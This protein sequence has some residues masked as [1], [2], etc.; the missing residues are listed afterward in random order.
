MKTAV[1]KSY[2]SR[3]TPFSFANGTLIVLLCLI[4]LYPLWYCL[5]SSFSDGALIMQGKITIWP[6][7]FNMENYRVLLSYSMIGRAYI[8]TLFYVIAGTTLS[9]ALTL[10]AAYPL[11]RPEFKA[12]RAMSFFIAFTMLFNGGMVP[13]FIVVQGLGLMDTVLAFILPIA[14]SAYNVIVLRTFMQ[15]IPE[16]LIEAGKI[17]GC[18]HLLIFIAI[19]IPYSLIGI[20]T[21]MLFYLVAYWNSFMPGILY[22]MVKPQ[23]LPMQNILRKIVISE[24]SISESTVGN[25]QMAKGV[26]YAAIVITALPLLCVYPFLQKYFEKGL[27]FGGIKG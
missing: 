7:G 11:T 9:I 22:I 24:E 27:M 14:L 3:I 26:Q 2:F 23:L 21:V 13:T 15:T 4:T 16:E 17:D 25:A 19:V 12:R 18:G 6:K 10:L 1:K 20:I 8:N 5:V